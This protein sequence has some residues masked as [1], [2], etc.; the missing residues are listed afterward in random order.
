MLEG[1]LSEGTSLLRH[2]ALELANHL[3]ITKIAIDDVK[4]IATV[5]GKRDGKYLSFTIEQRDCDEAQ[6]DITEKFKRK[7]DYKNEVKRLYKSGLKQTEIAAR[8]NISQSFVS[9]LLNSN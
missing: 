9:R 5:N 1:N 3:N 7:S 2:F 4:G 8:L 6:L